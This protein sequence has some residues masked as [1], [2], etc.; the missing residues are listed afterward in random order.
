MGVKVTPPSRPPSAPLTPTG[1][2]GLPT[3]AGDAL[4]AAAPTIAAAAAV[5]PSAFTWSNGQARSVKPVERRC[6]WRPRATT[7]APVGAAM[8]TWTTRAGAAPTMAAAT[9]VHPSA[10]TRSNGQARS[11]KPVEMGVLMEAAPRATTRAPALVVRTTWTTRARAA[12]TMP[13]QRP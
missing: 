11:V 1:G 12:P 3:V 2:G 9:A 10:S 13:P 8:T 6:W 5:D 4:A 7:R